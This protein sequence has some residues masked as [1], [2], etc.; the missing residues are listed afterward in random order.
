[1]PSAVIGALRVN[2][3]IDSAAFS[4]GLKQAQSKL[5][6]FGK[7]MSSIGQS[8]SLRVTAPIGLAGAAILRTAGNFE[9]GMNRV[10]AALGASS[11]EM[12]Q[13]SALA[14]D[15]GKS[16]V[17]SATEAAGAIEML[18]K[19]GV[20]TA[21]ILDG[22]LAASLNLAAASG[23]ELAGAADLATDVMLNFNKGAGDL[24]KVV[25]GV[26]GVLLA[27]K[28]GFDDY[29]LALAQAGGVAG[30]LGVT[31]EDFNAVI[32]ATS[33]RFASGSD[34]GTS[35]KTFLQRLVP[36][37]KAAA[38]AMQEL[39]LEF[40][41]AD[42]SLKSMTAVAAE[43]QTA[44]S[45]LSDEER[46]GALTAI[47]GSDAMRTAI[48][49]MEQ[50]ASGIQRLDAAIESA[51]AT[52][53]AAART[54]GWAGALEELK[55]AFEELSIAI[56]SSGLIE[57]A[58]NFVR[59]VTDIV[60]AVSAADPRLVNFGVVI[61]G[62]SAAIAPVLIALGAMATGIA[63]ISAPVAA[64]A[65][66]I[67]GLTTAIVAF[68]PEIINAK[69]AL[70]QFATEGFQAVQQKVVEFEAFLVGL[71][72]RFV[73]LG[74]DLIEG[75]WSG[76]KERWSALIGGVTGLFTGLVDK[77]RSTFGVHSPSTIFAEI[78]R[79]LVQGLG[80]GIASETG[81][82]E[83]DVQTFAQSLGQLFTDVLSGATSFGEGLRNIISQSLSNV[84][85]GLIEKGFSGIFG[86][87]KIPGF[88]YGTNYAPGGLALVGERGPELVNLPRG[89][90][91]FPHG[92]SP[93]SGRV[94]IVL[95][96]GLE[97]RF[98]NRAA[99]QSV[100][101]TRTGMAEVRRDVP[102]I[103]VETQKRAG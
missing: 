80:Q 60:N 44:L 101:I 68:W 82:V 88:A 69:D 20:S 96:P 11:G 27:S 29:R 97:A 67:A 12:A 99:E 79:N 71:R 55:G 75:L 61:L 43:L 59:M 86:M 48:G 65:V 9:S 84:G 33:A 93:E 4:D 16:T 103:M 98:L 34:A 35:F 5:A 95:G 81:Q 22:V 17:F 6:G 28:F 32:A 78:G 85:G 76:I 52:E 38:S 49:L 74:R 56:A 31:L 18:A 47:F 2:L 92:S 54:R 39:G 13:L 24:G 15:L 23:T 1:M 83:S 77:A 64:V 91:V 58:T 7:Q 40:F 89:S 37:S 94:E 72:D 42:G 8:M 30:G 25:D 26:S 53:Q 14:R 21:D 100:A 46:S 90:Q 36:Q 57:A 41:N 73:Q 87:L 102:K 50:G 19:N 45:G 51:S 10:Q 3:G 70:V 63:A 62:I 66:G